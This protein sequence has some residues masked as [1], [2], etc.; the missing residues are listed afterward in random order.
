[1]QAMASPR[2]QS[3]GP[4]SS[5]AWTLAACTIA[6]LLT[7]TALWAN[8]VPDSA[9]TVRNLLGREQPISALGVPRSEC[10]ASTSNK[11]LR[12]WISHAASVSMPL[13]KERSQVQGLSI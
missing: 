13:L 1:M 5:N 2:V 12:S 3:A 8:T 4:V 9:G 6:F 10:G 11:A 7:V